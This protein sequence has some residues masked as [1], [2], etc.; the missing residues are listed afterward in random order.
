MGFEQDKVTYQQQQYL[1]V[2]PFLFIA[3]AIITM[4]TYKSD[5]YYQLT[6]GGKIPQS[7]Q[8]GTCIYTLFTIVG[9][10]LIPSVQVNPNVTDHGAYVSTM[11]LSLIFLLSLSAASFYL[12]VLLV[13]Q[14]NLNNYDAT[15]RRVIIL[16]VIIQM[17]IY[18]RLLTSLL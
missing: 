10:L 9:Y 4:F 15:S 5:I 6:N 8:L 14:L 13:R 1:Q 3:L 18:V 16:E 7:V 2:M 17:I 11:T 12:T